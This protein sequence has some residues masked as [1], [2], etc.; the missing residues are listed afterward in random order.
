LKV[1]PRLDA[2]YEISFKYNGQNEDSE[3]KIVVIPAIS[4]TVPEIPNICSGTET[5]LTVTNVQPVGTSVTWTDDPT[6]IEGKNSET[7]R[8]KPVFKAE[9][10]SNHQ[11]RYNYN[12]I[13]YNSICDNSKPYTVTVLVD[14]PL[15]GDIIGDLEIC[16]GE[17]TLLDAE[18]YLASQ[19][20][21]LPDTIGN[22]TTSK[23]IVRPVVST[24]YTVDMSRGLCTASDTFTVNVNSNPRIEKI[25]SVALRDRLIVLEAG[26]G[27]GPFMY[28]I[29]SKDFDGMDL[30]TDL[31]FAKH[32]VN[33]RDSKGCMTS[34][35]FNLD[36]PE[37]SIPIVFTPNG[38]GV[39]DTWS[40][41]AIAEVYPNSVVSIYD[42]FGKLLVQFLGAEAEGWDGT[43]QGNKLPSTDYW[44]QITIEEIDKEYSGHFTLIRR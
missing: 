6:I 16:E 41:P 25:D 9:G 36:P 34:T 39:N 7:V 21:W 2:K 3:E 28:Q 14:E 10:S 40:I 18:S 20:K 38:D 11:Y 19:Y 24:Q 31:A 37:I 23:I 42:R 5:L 27:T 15:V 44:Y 17:E 33:V 43:Y 8:V 1:S 12:V 4:L 32:V 30:K 29:D 22:L 26:Y 35:V 13:A